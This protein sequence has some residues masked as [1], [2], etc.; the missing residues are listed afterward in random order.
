MNCPKCGSDRIRVIE[1]SYP[2]AY[3]CKDCEYVWL[4]A[5]QAL[6]DE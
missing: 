6:I 5:P 3:E 2:N 4:K 1:S